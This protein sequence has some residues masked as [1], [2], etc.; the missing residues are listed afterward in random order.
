MNSS[1][2][3]VS[4]GCETAVDELMAVIPAEQLDLIGG[5]VMNNPLYE[6]PGA[7]N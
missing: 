7:R 2:I 5:G 3:H 1:D 6:G 4:G